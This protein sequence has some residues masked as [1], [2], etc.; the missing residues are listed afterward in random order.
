MNASEKTSVEE[1]RREIVEYMTTHRLEENMNELLNELVKDRP[2][3]PY[4]DLSQAIELKSG[5]SQKIIN[6]TARSVAGSDGR[7]ALEAEVETIRGVFRAVVSNMGKGS[8]DHS[9]STILTLLGDQLLN[10]DPAKQEQ[11]DA[12]LSEDD[13][14][15]ADAVLALSIVSNTEGGAQQGGGGPTEGGTYQRVQCGCA[16]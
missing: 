11:I 7:P 5:S 12:I 14:V 1:D 4:L 9:V 3:D 8:V 6:V 15:P 16:N 13:S 2:D 10:K